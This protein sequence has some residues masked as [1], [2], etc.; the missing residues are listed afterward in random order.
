M[1]DDFT[2]LLT[3]LRADFPQF[4]FT[5]A[6]VSRWSPSEHRVYYR[7]NLTELFHE[8]GHAVLNHQ[9]FVQ[10]IELIKME[11]DAW[12]RGASIAKAYNVAITDSIIENALDDYRDWLHARSKC[13][14]C[15]Q[16]GVQSRTTLDYQ[17]LNC[18]T[19]WLANDSRRVGL[20]RRKIS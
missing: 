20:K 9:Q 6:T 5:T 16:T 8:L 10:D 15:G 4:D 1:E 11:R 3:R 13:P 12:T 17:C 18:D 2:G 19:R 14:N 7:S